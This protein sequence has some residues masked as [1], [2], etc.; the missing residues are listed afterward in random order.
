MGTGPRVSLFLCW[1]SCE[2]DVEPYTIVAGIPARK[3]GDRNLD[4]KYTFNGS[5][6]HFI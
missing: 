2:K 1:R 4:L 5:H 6:R 3:V